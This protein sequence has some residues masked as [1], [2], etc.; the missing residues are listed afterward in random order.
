MAPEYCATVVFFPFDDI[1]M[2]YM[3]LTGRS[4]ETLARIHA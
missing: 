4:E 2:Q 1:T 3:H